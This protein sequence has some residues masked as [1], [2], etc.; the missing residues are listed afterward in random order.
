MPRQVDITPPMRAILIDWLVD[1][2][3]EFSLEQ[4]TF[5]LAIN[6]VDRFLSRRSVWKRH[7]QLVGTAAL[8]IAASVSSL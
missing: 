5:Y 7:L 3:I 1:V 4:E 6:Y 8:L 2:C